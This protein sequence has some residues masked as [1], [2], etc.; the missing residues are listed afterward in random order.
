MQHDVLDMS[1]SKPP[2][3]SRTRDVEVEAVVL[4][5]PTE[6]LEVVPYRQ[7]HRLGRIEVDDEDLSHVIPLEGIEQARS[8]A[9][10]SSD[11][12]FEA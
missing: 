8:F 10:V 1:M 5:I 11:A 12:R 6:G 4:G 3:C 9:R 7:S 2:R